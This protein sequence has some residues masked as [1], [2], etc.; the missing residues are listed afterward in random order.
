MLFLKFLLLFEFGFHLI[1]FSMQFFL[2]EK[3]HYKLIK[4]IIYSG[5][6]PFTPY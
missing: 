5:T 2:F 1:V 3:M 6:Y 4:R